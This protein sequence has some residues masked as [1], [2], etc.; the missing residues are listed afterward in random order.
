M[1][2]KYI[3]EELHEIR[4]KMNVISGSL[5]DIRSSID[6]HKNNTGFWRSILSVIGLCAV[7]AGIDYYEKAKKIDK[8]L[9]YNSD[10]AII[11]DKEDDALEC[12]QFDNCSIIYIDEDSGISANDIAVKLVGEDG[13]VYYYNSQTEEKVLI[14]QK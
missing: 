13:N 12:M 8:V 7:F 6:S 4:K 14:N 1:N 9:L 5:T 3:E 2:N 11:F 10:N